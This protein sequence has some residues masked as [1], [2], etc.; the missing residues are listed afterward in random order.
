MEMIYVRPEKC[1]GCRSCE[2]ACRVA[3]AEE[4]SLAAA[5]SQLHPPKKRLFVGQQGSVK[6]PALCRHCEDAPCV[7]ACITG[8]LHK[9]GRGFI[10]CRE[11]RCIGCWS[12]ILACP[13]GVISRNPD[14]PAAVKCD[15]CPEREIPAC[16]AACPTKALRIVDT[17]TL[18]DERRKE[19]LLRAG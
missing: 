3:H 18:S 6:Q 13:F 5:V 12:C 8:S 11:E 9:D 7:A 2:I 10:R 4:P 1:L 14:R 16:V 15:R 17:E 19:T